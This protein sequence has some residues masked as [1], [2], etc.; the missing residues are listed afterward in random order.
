[1]KEAQTR[2]VT[3]ILRG[4]NAG[5][6]QAPARLVPFVYEELR[7]LARHHLAAERRDH[8]LQPTALVHEAYLR[9][10]DQDRG[11]WKNRAQFFGIAA[12]LMRRILVDYARAHNAAKRGG[13]V[14]HLSLDDV[15]ISLQDRAGELLALDAALAELAKVDVRKSRVVELRF[16][17]GLTV[18][19]TAEAMEINSAMVRRD[20]TV[21][22]AWLHRNIKSAA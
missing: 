6:G 21:A 18:E 9:L 20:W 15:E 16:F 5:D 2:E 7:R 1:M 19:E 3:E 17:G 11:E 14:E 12:Q 10:V 22:K 8:T 4:W 13:G